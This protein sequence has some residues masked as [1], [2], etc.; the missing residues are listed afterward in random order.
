VW[1]ESREYRRI[2]L[3]LAR[4]LIVGKVMNSVGNSEEVNASV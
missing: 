1:G 4:T 2:G 3:R